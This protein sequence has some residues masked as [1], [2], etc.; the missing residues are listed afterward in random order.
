MGIEFRSHRHF[1]PANAISILRLTLFPGR[2]NLKDSHMLRSIF[3]AGL[4]LAT[5]SSSAQAADCGAVL[6]ELTKA[7]SGNL[8]MSGDRKAAMLRMA[9]SG[10]DHCMAGDTKYSGNVRDMLMQQ[11][12]ESLGGR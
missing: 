4:L 7:V 10:Y 3:C 2:R 8:T 5:V 1:C 12:K 6:D 11:I 9:S